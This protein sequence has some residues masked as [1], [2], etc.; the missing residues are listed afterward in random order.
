MRYQDVRIGVYEILCDQHKTPR[1]TS[2]EIYV[3]RLATSILD[4]YQDLE[5]LDD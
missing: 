2:L 5:I 4:K 1:L 3:L